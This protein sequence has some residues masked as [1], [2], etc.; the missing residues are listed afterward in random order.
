MHAIQLFAC[1]R[2]RV[3]PISMAVKIIAESTSTWQNLIKGPIGPP[4]GREPPLWG[5][6]RQRPK[7]QSSQTH[8]LRPN[9]FPRSNQRL[10]SFSEEAL[11]QVP[12]S[13][14]H[15]SSSHFPIWLAHLVLHIHTYTYTHIY[16]YIYSKFE[17]F[18]IYI[19]TH[20]PQLSLT[21]SSET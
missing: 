20:S 14:M 18:S 16:N 7:G 12:P 1:L 9:L 4:P 3:P 15:Y 21:Y 17:Y 6:A 5:K 11:N 13:R 8:N 19:L 10:L 2:K